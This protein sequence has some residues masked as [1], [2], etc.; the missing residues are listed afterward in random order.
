MEI[1]IYESFINLSWY[2]IKKKVEKER[3]EDNEEE[4]IL[5][6]EV[7]LKKI[8]ENRFIWIEWSNNFREYLSVHGVVPILDH[9]EEWTSF[10]QWLSSFERRIRLDPSWV[11]G[12]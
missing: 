6:S 12:D 1:Q 9:Y 2:R 7:K 5:R 11:I 8:V 4:K 10:R 3:Q